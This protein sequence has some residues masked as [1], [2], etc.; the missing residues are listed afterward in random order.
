MVYDA[1]QKNRVALGV[2][3]TVHTEIIKR[4]KQCF[5]LKMRVKV[6]QLVGD[7]M[8]QFVGSF[9]SLLLCF[10]FFEFFF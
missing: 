7:A 9:A 8:L 6:I 10:S 1:F 5:S 4:P 2:N 3:V